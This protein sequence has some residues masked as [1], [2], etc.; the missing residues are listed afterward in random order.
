MSNLNKK[1]ILI[2]GSHRS[3]STWTGR[4]I[5]HSPSVAYIHEP[6]NLH[7]RPGICKAHFN[8]Q[9]PYICKEN[10]SIYVQ[11][12]EDCLS[13]KYY[14]LADLKT[15]KSLKDI[16]RSIL[17]YLRFTKYRILKK[18]PLV[19]DPIAVF[20]AEWLA[21]RFNMDVVIIIRHPAAF[22][23]SLKK[24]KWSHPFEHFLQQPLLMKHHLHEYKSEIEKFS[25]NKRN[26]IDQ[27]I[28]LWN[29]IHY[30]ILYYQNNNP[31]WIFVKHED[32]SKRPWKEFKNL[33]NKLDLTYSL[34]IEEDIKTFSCP[35]HADR[36]QPY[37]KSKI[38]RYKR[39]LADDHSDKRK[40]NSQ[41]NIWSW[42]KRLTVEEIKKIKRKTYK[43]ASKF[44]TE[45]DWIR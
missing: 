8:Y 32:L 39:R 34:N 21:Q 44:Y 29:L 12:L 2:T 15:A 14:F 4:M 33:Y 3:G 9:F 45:E 10:E 16:A 38:Q 27:A 42:Q 43:I 22:A 20:C 37:I 13:F 35:G 17:Y 24:V 11:D 30:M 31:N 23:G 6:F 19:K 36:I 28:L 41:L 25:E 5:A 7:H 40:R 18:R 1:P 26:I